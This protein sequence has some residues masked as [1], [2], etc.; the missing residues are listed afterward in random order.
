MTTTQNGTRVLMSGNEAVCEGA[1]AAGIRFYAG[2]PITPC[3]EISEAMARR[4]PQVGGKYI[5]SEDEV[6]AIDFLM[7]GAIAGAK[8][9]TATAGP[10][11]SLMQDGIGMATCAEIPMV[12]VDVQRD[13]PGLSSATRSSQMDFM[14]TRWGPHGDRL[15]IVLSPASV[16]D[17][18]WLTVKAVNLSERF[19]T[20]VILLSE[21]LL[22]HMREVIVKPDYNTVEHVERPRPTVTPEQYETYAVNHITDIPPMADVGS[23]YRNM[24]FLGKADKPGADLP[25]MNRWELQAFAVER[26]HQKILSRLDEM[27]MW[28]AFDT[29]DA[30]VLLAAWGSQSRVAHYVQQEARR[31]GLRVGLFRPITLWPYPEEALKSAA[32]NVK[33]IIVPEMN[34]GQM[35]LEIERILRHHPASITGVNHLGS[36]FITPPEIFKAIE[37]VI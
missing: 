21:G 20:V 34:R 13:G 23:E 6:G 9:M 16:H 2:Y 7:G 5:Q 11:I 17:C 33:A 36:T 19:R 12:V 24:F 18:F 35:R 26:L 31:Q 25:P 1:I 27:L 3:T 10:G 8:V 37:E 14:Q 4:L 28:E 22:G 15:C 30:E 29:E 32:A